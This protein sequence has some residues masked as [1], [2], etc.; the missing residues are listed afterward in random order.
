V[1]VM[2]GVHNTITITRLNPED[3]SAITIRAQVQSFTKAGSW[4]KKH[5]SP[6]MAAP[7]DG[8]KVTATFMKDGFSSVEEAQEWVTSVK[9]GIYAT[10]NANNLANGVMVE[11][12]VVGETVKP[13]FFSDWAEEYGE[14]DDDDD[15]GDG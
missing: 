9:Q 4:P 11:V 10:L 13:A 5:Q 14:D 7:F 12:D 1:S 15:D 6:S 3:D 8:R 2:V